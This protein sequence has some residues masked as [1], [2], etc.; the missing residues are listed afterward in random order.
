MFESAWKKIGRP[1]MKPGKPADCL[2]WHF[3]VQTYS[4]KIDFCESNICTKHVKVT[5][6]MLLK[7]EVSQSSEKIVY[8]CQKTSM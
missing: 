5:Y 1:A 4:S 8:K 2:W 7:N 6:N 3:L